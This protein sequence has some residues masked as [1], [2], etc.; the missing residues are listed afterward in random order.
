MPRERYTLKK[1]ISG[2]IV[3]G[4]L[5][6]GAS[7]FADSVSLIGQKV[8]GLYSVEKDGAKVAD[9]VV[10]N[11]TAYAPVRAVSDATGTG[12][13]VEGKRIIIQEKEEVPTVDSSNIVSE[14]YK[15]NKIDGLIR[16][17]SNRKETISQ[18]ETKLQTYKIQLESATITDYD[19]RVATESVAD[20]EERLKTE[21]DALAQAEARLADLQK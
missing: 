8:Q 13:T 16:G 14:Q 21:R 9:A 3:G 12:L 17:V 19:K 10:I 1:F 11:G 6:A 18:L 5:F 4:F 2:I 7:V 15:Q 20:L